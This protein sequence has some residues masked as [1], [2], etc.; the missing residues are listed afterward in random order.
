MVTSAAVASL[1]ASLGVLVNGG[2]QRRHEVS[3]KRAEEARQLRDLKRERLWSGLMAVAAA[4]MGVQEANVDFMRFPVNA[5]TAR[6][7]GE[8]LYALVEGKRADIVL[9]SRKG[10]NCCSRSWVRSGATRRWASPGSRTWR[11]RGLREP[12]TRR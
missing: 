4:A 1:V 11:W 2:L 12:T 10:R 8:E 6:A 3:L 7:R 9:S 5:Q